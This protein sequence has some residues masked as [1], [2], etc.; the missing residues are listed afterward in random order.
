[1]AHRASAF[2]ADMHE[3]AQSGELRYAAARRLF[4]VHEDVVVAIAATGG[5]RRAGVAAR[6]GQAADAEKFMSTWFTV[7]VPFFMREVVVEIRRRHR[8]RSMASRSTGSSSASPGTGLGDFDRSERFT[9]RQLRNFD[10]ALQQEELAKPAPTW[11][12]TWRS[13]CGAGRAL[14]TRMRALRKK[15]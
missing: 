13:R 3:L 12:R 11:S 4:G 5:R 14:Q 15:R 8:L 6:P 1:V 10:R 9:E 2:I 7:N